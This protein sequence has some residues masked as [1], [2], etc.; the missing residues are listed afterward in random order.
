M[1]W[2]SGKAGACK[3]SI[4][5]SNLGAT[6]F[7]TPVIV[8]PLMLFLVATPIG[9]L[10][11]IT[12]R[13]IETL[14]SCDYILCEDTRHSIILLRHYDI[15]KP[16]RSFHKFNE[17]KSEDYIIQDL[18][19]GKCISLISDAGTPGI[20]DPGSLLVKRCIEEEISITTIPGPCALIG[21]LTASGLP[22]NSFQF[23]GFLP[24]KEQ[25]LIEILITTLHYQG[26]SIA[27]ESPKRIKKTLH[28]LAKIAPDTRIVIARE[29][30]KKFEEYIRGNAKD[31]LE[32]LSTLNIKGE[33]VLCIEGVAQ[34][35][36]NAITAQEHVAFVEKEYSIPRKEA[37]KLVAQLRGIPKRDLY[38]SM[39]PPRN[40]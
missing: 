36:W 33:I 31:V 21:A 11:D 12:Y 20:A 6:F 30:T 4:P 40:Q 39:L 13:A 2:P 24:K 17:S 19:D 16:L 32:N 3:A 28:A 7:F 27:Y 18:R 10:G 8:S 37:L 1:A 29:M 26:I 22:T 5:S 15:K 38:K 9:N 23:L 25:A 34:H 14:K 35:R